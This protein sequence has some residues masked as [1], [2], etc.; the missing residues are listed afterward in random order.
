[1]KSHKVLSSL[2]AFLLVLFVAVPL[3]AQDTG[4]PDNASRS[5]R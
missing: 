2:P 3:V 5:P 4:E 1:M